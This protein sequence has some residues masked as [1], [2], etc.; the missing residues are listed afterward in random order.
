MFK[1]GSSF[2]WLPATEVRGEGIFLRFDYDAILEWKKKSSEFFAPH[3]GYH[4]KW[5]QKMLEDGSPNFAR[6]EEVSETLLMVHTFSHVFM[7]QLIFKSGY[8]SS[9]LR[10]R[11]YV[12]EVDDTKMAGL[13]IYTAAGDSEGTLGGLVEQARPG[14]FEKILFGA[15]ESE[16]CSNDP[17]CIETHRQGLVSLNGAACHS[18]ALMPETSCEHNNTLL[19]RKYLFGDVDNKAGFFSP[20]IEYL[21]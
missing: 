14:N 4:N 11:L 19:D 7:R 21:R 5:F 2:N 8:D 20:M 13:L 6:A 17:V 9:S 3:I 18:C 16:I 10:E 12:S 1:K 15:M